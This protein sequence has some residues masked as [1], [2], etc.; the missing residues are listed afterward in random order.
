MPLFRY[1]KSLV[2][3]RAIKPPTT[4]LGDLPVEI[5][6]KIADYLSP[7]A[8]VCLALTCHSLK[9]ILSKCLTDPSV[10][11]LV[12]FQPF[13]PDPIYWPWF[14]RHRPSLT[15]RQRLLVLLARDG[16]YAYCLSCLKMQPAPHFSERIRLRMATGERDRELGPYGP[17]INVCPC[18]CITFR[19]THNL[20]IHD[21]CRGFVD[22]GYRRTHFKIEIWPNHFVRVKIKIAPSIHTD[23]QLVIR[24]LYQWKDSRWSAGFENPTKKAAADWADVYY[25]RPDVCPY[26]NLDFRRIEDKIRQTSPRFI[27]SAL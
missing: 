1:L 8:A 24:V 26:L 12:S 19:G 2:K 6:L 14:V 4:R 22:H 7:E 27:A 9:S 3:K 23:G 13:F 25:A 15:P 11:S 20:T 16:G 21:T 17:R 18:A 10:R 5:I